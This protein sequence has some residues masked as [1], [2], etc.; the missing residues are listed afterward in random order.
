MTVSGTI[1]AKAVREQLNNLRA[2]KKVSEILIFQHFLFAF[3]N[4]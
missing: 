2:V 3:S 1:T 4:T